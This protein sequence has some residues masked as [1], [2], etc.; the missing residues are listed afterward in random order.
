MK[1][2]FRRVATARHARRWRL[3]PSLVPSER[4]QSFRAVLLVLRRTV[5]GW[6]VLNAVKL[7]QPPVKYR[8]KTGQFLHGARFE[9]PEAPVQRGAELLSHS[10][11][12][13][14]DK[15]VER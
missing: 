12:N 13:C 15:M 8:R 6:E 7:S 3:V 4:Q 10:C 11:L 1:P 14:S 5:R 9:S 2:A